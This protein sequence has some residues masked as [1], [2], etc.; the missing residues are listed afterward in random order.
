VSPSP[1]LVGV[2]TDEGDGSPVDHAQ[3]R[4]ERLARLQDSMRV[5]DLEVLLLFNEP[6]IRYATGATAMPVWAMSTMV[7]C[8]LVPVEGEP[9]LFEHPN[10]IHR[11][12]RRAGDVRPMHAWEFYDDPGPEATIWARETV[13]AVRELGAA[14]RLLG[15]DRLGT[16]GFLALARE[17]IDP[18]DSAPVTQRA[19]EVKTS[20]EVALFELNGVLVIRMLA[21]FE[22]AIATGVREVDLLAALSGVMLREGGEYL[23]TNTVCS[24]PNTNP[25][26]AEA[27]ARRMESG[28]LVFVDT[29]TVGIEGIFFCVSRTFPVGEAHPT[30]AQRSTY[31]AAH[32]WLESMKAVIQPGLTCGEI[33]H[34]AP[35]LPEQY[36]PQRYEVMVHG[37]GLEEESPSVCHPGDRQSNAERVIEENMALVVEVY[38]GEVDG[39]HGVKLGDEVLV[40][41]GGTRVLAP[42]P[43]SDALL[44]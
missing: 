39:D 6:N 25:W 5:H 3:L 19:R 8:A 43:F 17:G 1:T 4:D 35:K 40:T 7:R 33:A 16:P 14:S 44:A 29:D 42:Y 12:R 21:A 34:R 27:T 23:A 11:S 36:L 15:V 10:S 38:A 28:D 30:T 26:R 20:Q 2:R 22:A 31:G 18:V 41:A 37:V 24:G 32:D 13:A 9:I